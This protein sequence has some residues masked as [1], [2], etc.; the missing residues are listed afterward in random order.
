V[1]VN[2][3]EAAIDDARAIARVQV[4][5][6]R[7]AYQGIVAEEFL[8]SLSEDHRTI[9]WSEILKQPA[10]FVVEADEIVGFVNGYALDNTRQSR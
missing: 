4:R 9:R 7:S 1:F 5:T 6:W 8:A 3:R 10:T 2:L